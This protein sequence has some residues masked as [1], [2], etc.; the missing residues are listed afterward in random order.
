MGTSASRPLSDANPPADGEPAPPFATVATE[1][2]LE[3]TPPQGQ[4]KAAGPLG[5]E[6][7]ATLDD[8]TWSEGSA[9]DFREI[10]RVSPGSITPYCFDHLRR[11]VILTKVAPAE[12]GERTFLYMDQRQMATNVYAVPYSEFCDIV[13]ELDG[14]AG[15][16]GKVTFL[17][18]TGRCGSTLLCKL[19]GQANGMIS[20]SEPDVYTYLG[21]LQIMHADDFEGGML[22]R[23]TRSVTR[24]HYAAAARDTG[25]E[26]CIK[27]R[28]QVIALA[29]TI[30]RAIPGSKT[31]YL[32]RA[33]IPTIDSF[34]M[35]FASNF[36]ARM[37]RWL[38][39]D[40]WYLHSTYSGLMPSFP[41]MCPW[42]V[43]P[44]P[45][46][47]KDIWRPLGT[48]GLT[49]L[50]FIY[51]MEVAMAQQKAGTFDVVLRYEDLCC[52][53][54]V[55]VKKVLSE[56]G[57]DNAAGLED[58]SAIFD[59]DAHKGNAK[60][61]SSRKKG[62]KSKKSLYI[63]DADMPLVNQLLVGHKQLIDLGYIIPG[64]LTF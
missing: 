16:M 43:V 55:A 51:N 45:R 26:M 27:T 42:L 13:D 1:L 2:V 64:T 29:E 63:S 11:R 60:T 12:M 58:A 31:I 40:G 47:P 48:V 62:D 49:T 17:H 44:D 21:W 20:L 30:K 37:I 61:A 50:M 25:A 5:D 57:N 9:V 15:W 22:D 10:L 38:N 14:D 18:S 4:R 28:S 35:A 32:Y 46:F 54:E 6:S 33:P 19:L 24:V 7:L 59:E 36:V 52:E 34:C 56:C 23:L 41:V 8:F 53:R 3:G 39:M